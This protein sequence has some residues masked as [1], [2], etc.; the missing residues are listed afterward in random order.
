MKHVKV[1]SVLSLLT[2]AGTASA[3]MSSTVTVT[4]D[5]DFRGISQSA[6]DP[7]LQASFDYAGNGWYAGA[8]ASNVDFGDGT[9]IELDLYGGFS[10]KTDAGLGWDAGLVFYTYDESRNNY[11]E[12]FTAFTYD[13]FKGK[14]AYS[15]DFAG[16]S[17]SPPEHRSGFYVSGDAN[18][19]L[20]S[21]FSFL[22][23]LGYSAGSYWDHAYDDY[24]DY[25]VGVGYTVQTAQKVDLALKYVNTHTSGDVPY[26]TSDVF[27]NE[28][29]LILTAATTF[30]W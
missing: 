16:D 27:N 7:A 9:D 17:D 6:E 23:H 19:P 13:W 28:A 21:N 29:R 10:G 22:A 8:W 24:F 25:S 4:N 20:P 12:I 1:W 18:V 11:P 15:N 2:V 3:E 30:R 26:I 5:Y 14:L